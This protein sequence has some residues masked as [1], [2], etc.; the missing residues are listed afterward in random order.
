[1][2]NGAHVRPAPVERQVVIAGH[3]DSALDVA[4]ADQHR[5]PV[6]KA[7]HLVET[8][9]AGEVAA[10]HEHVGLSADDPLR[11]LAVLLVRVTDEAEPGHAASDA[12]NCDWRKSALTMSRPISPHSRCSAIR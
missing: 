6:R 4:L 8:T 3:C 5:A 7:I 12:R 9:A 11:E 2:G 1:V 10:V